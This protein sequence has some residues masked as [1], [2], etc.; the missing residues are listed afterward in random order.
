MAPSFARGATLMFQKD[1]LCKITDLA[2]R[3][4]YLSHKTKSQL[5]RRRCF[6]ISR[7]MISQSKTKQAGFLLGRVEKRKRRV[8][9][10]VQTISGLQEWR[11]EGGKRRVW[12]YGQRTSYR[13]ASRGWK[14]RCWRRRGALGLLVRIRRPGCLLLLVLLQLALKVVAPLLVLP[15]SLPGIK[16][17][18]SFVFELALQLVGDCEVG[19]VHLERLDLQVALPLLDSCC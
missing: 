13:M 18:L 14:R 7:P 16:H 2:I 3:S 8:Q 1:A 4:G 10:R 12:V 15:E 19:V 11:V 6:P 9:V 5:L 17:Q